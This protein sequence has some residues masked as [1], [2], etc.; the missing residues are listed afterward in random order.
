M[1]SNG[2]CP[3]NT[4]YI[5]TPTKYPEIKNMAAFIESLQ[6]G[7]HRKYSHAKWT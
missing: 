4:W 6:I 7:E 2:Q 5:S 3:L 1:L